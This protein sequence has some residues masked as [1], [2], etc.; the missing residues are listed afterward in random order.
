MVWQKFDV[1]VWNR[2]AD[3]C[4]ELVAAGAKQVSTPADVIRACD[5]TF[6]CLADPEIAEAVA[7]GPGTPYLPY[8]PLICLSFMRRPADLRVDLH[9]QA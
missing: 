1:T 9:A 7:L 8:T 2:S 4:A 3:K 6:A 5:I